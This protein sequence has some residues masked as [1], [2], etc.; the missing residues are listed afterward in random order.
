MKYLQDAQNIYE[1]EGLRNLTAKTLRTAGTK[2]LDNTAWKR[3]IISDYCDSPKYIN[4]GGGTFTRPH[5]RV[6]DYYTE[7]YNYSSIFVDYNINLENRGKWPI[8]DSEYDLIY[9]SHT[10]EHLT[11]AAVEHTLAECYRILKPGGVFRIAVPGTGIAV[12]KYETSDK[13]WFE[14]V[15]LHRDTRQEF[16]ADHYGLKEYALEFYLISFF[17]TYLARGEYNL[18]FAKVRNDYQEMALPEFLDTYAFRVT[19]E[20]QAKQPGWHRNWFTASKL[21]TL[22]EQ[23]GFEANQVTESR[24]KQSQAAEMCATEFDTRPRI[25]LYIEAVK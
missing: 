17:A 2:L 14:S 18:D 1:A 23:A 20:M 22:L 9:S 4:V 7:Y 8:A 5:W 24:C 10:L 25:S 16:K 19:D 13:A 11:P 12:G 15:W 3:R 6:L 21:S